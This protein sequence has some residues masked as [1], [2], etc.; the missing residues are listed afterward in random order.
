MRYHREGT[1]PYV[2]SPANDPK[3]PAYTAKLIRLRNR[4]FIDVTLPTSVPESNIHIVTRLVANGFLR[5]IIH[6]YGTL[7]LFLQWR[8]RGYESW[9]LS[10]A[11][12][13]S[14]GLL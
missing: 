13:S 9:S 2:L 5:G 4:Q 10:G 6:P 8:V 7:L 12:P 1:N 3:R 11:P 14:K